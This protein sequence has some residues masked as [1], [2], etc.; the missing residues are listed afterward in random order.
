[1]NNAVLRFVAETTML[2]AMFVAWSVPLMTEWAFWCGLLA[3]WIFIAI[4]TV[5]KT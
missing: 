2:V 5:W 3:F 4:I 1:M